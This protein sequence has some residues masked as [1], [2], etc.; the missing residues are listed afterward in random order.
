M[1][2]IVS[3]LLRVGVALLMGDRVVELPG[4]QDQISYHAL[5]V[6]LLNG[7]GFSFDSGWYPFTPA[8]TPTAHWSFA[9][10]LYLLGVYTIFG[11]HPLIARVIQAAFVGLLTGFLVYRLSKRVFG[12]T[13]ALIAVGMAAVYTYFIYY[14]AALM[15]EALFM[16]ASLGV[17]EFAYL[18]VER[19]TWLRALLLGSVLAI[20][21]LL[22]QAILLFLPVLFIWL[23]LVGRKKLA[24]YHFIVPLFI[25]ILIVAPWT[26][27]NYRVYNRFLL[28]N[29]NAGYA[30]YSSNHS[31]L[32]VKWTPENSV[33]SVPPDLQ[34]LNE[35]QMDS[36]LMRRS[37]DAVIDNP[38]RYVLLTFSKF[39]EYFKFWPSNSSGTT[40][41]LQRLFSFAWLLPLSL[42]GFYLARARLRD[43][44][45]PLL[46]VFTTAA[47][48]LLSWPTARYRV[49]TD[50]CLIPL[51]AFA[52][53]TLYTN[54]FKN[55]KSNRENSLL[56]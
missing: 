21:V 8:D 27:R 10:P 22:R 20:A 15:T 17:L 14:S 37:I 46:Y 41:N 18:L 26:W 48:Y 39:A 3:V 6:R 23:W 25:V 35:A 1:L 2:L 55:L 51:A 31:T 24:L 50:A 12:E 54:I 43:W 5:A 30:F 49:P 38:E 19:P 16:V 42:Y 9:Y 53:Y 28:L 4:I 33:A 29:S 47:T 13:V 56:D 34:G 52:V 36:I 44:A 40:S 45:L 7:Y 32:G 11:I